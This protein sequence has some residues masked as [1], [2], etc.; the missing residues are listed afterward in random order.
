M[1]KIANQGIL[2]LCILFLSVFVPE[3][4]YAY[5]NVRAT[6]TAV[7]S[8]KIEVKWNASDF[9]GSYAVYRRTSSEGVFQKISTTDDTVYRDVKVSPAVNYY[10][11]IVPINKANGIEMEGMQSTVKARAPMKVSIE[12]IKV[13]SPTQMQIFW[14]ASAGSTGYQLY[15]SEGKSGRYTE[16]AVI[17]GKNNCSYAD[18][19]VRPGKI[20]YYKVRPVSR[21][22]G[23][24]G[25]FSA[26]VMGR[27]VPKTSITSIASL[28]SDMM[29][30]TWKKVSNASSYEVYRS[31]KKDGG[32]KKLATF[33]SN[34]RKYTDKRVKSGKKY[35]YKVVAVGKLNGE[36]IT[37]GYSEAASFR[38]LQKVKI[39][40]VRVT[41]DDGL[42]IRWGKV[43]GATKYRIYRSTSRSGGFRR[44]AIVKASA[45]L[46]YTDNKVTSGA[47]Y[48]YKVQA[49]SDEKGVI[50]A[51]SG[52]RSDAL[53]ASTYY[54]I[55]GKTTVTADQMAA[56][57]NAS[58]K[59]FASSFYKNK[60]AKNIKQFCEIV[61]DECEK[62]GVRAEVVFAQVCLET[63]YL[64]FYG[65]VS[66]SQCNFSGLG[67]TDDGAAGATFPDIKTGIRAQ[68][69]HL[70]GYASKDDLN[71]KC[72]DPRFIY[73]SSRRGTAKY[74]QNLG[75]GNW[76]TD[77]DYA[78]KLMRLI[79]AMKSY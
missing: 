68:V 39:T 6:A 75:N 54:A 42:K 5:S 58:G 56:L 7:S 78:S 71:Q 15:R 55:M 32:Y 11:K 25:S 12:K 41:D 37:S 48:Y 66:M 69:Q 67:A 18:K 50:S 36:R 62:E 40:S 38:A 31:T 4:A 35:Y 33:K 46:S 10:Y 73:L 3:H 77:P 79:K 29:Q 51:G 76:A 1:K 60:G 34:V 74:V 26:P 16:L 27:T 72:V 17:S 65:Q 59:S 52:T 49:F 20:Y 45:G 23:S 13:K 70:K 57:F 14:K 24:V 19:S 43:A 30:I 53:G 61:I 2:L 64:Q 9:A 63:G 8:S 28:S 21:G 22:Q 47:T 44:I